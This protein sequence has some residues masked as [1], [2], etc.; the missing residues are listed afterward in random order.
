MECDVG[1]GKHK[2][3]RGF[4]DYNVYQDILKEIGPY[5]L[6]LELYRYGEPLLHKDILKMIELAEKQYNIL[7][8]ISTNF[9]MPLSEDFL[10]KIVKSGLSFMIIGADDIDQELYKKYRKGGD[11]NVVINNLK[12]LIRVKKE[13]NSQSPDIVWQSLI[14]NFNEHRR[15]TIEKYVMALGVNQ[16]TFVS[17]YLSP[18]NY[19]LRASSQVVRGGRKN[20]KTQI[21]SAKVTPVAIHMAEKFTLEVEV[22]NSAFKNEIPASG[23]NSG[24]RVGIKLADKNKNE[25]T[26]FERISFSKPL[27][28]GE[29]IFLKKEM[30]FN[31]NKNVEETVFFKIDLVMEH[32]FW[33]EQNLEIQSVPYFVEVKFND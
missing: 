11:V 33:F 13:M 27:R 10:R 4:M 16:F 21:L 19:D 32:Q 24:V 14:F 1:R 2:H 5:L 28:P 31:Q 7:V 29:K 3:T 20:K 15:D 9:A 22:I 6:Y 12:N 30:V 25:I 8:K 23:K 17:P 26:D 18:A